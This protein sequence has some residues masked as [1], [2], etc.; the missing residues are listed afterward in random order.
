M[1]TTMHPA[2]P[3]VQQLADDHEEALDLLDDFYERFYW[4]KDHPDYQEKV[5]AY[6]SAKGRTPR[7]YKH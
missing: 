1:V 4:I 3:A 6:L 2:V 7:P 5:R